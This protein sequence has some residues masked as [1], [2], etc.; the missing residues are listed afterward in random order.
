MLLPLLLTTAIFGGLYAT[1]GA[2]TDLQPGWRY[3]L[4]LPR[5]VAFP[6]KS[7]A[8]I[9][10]EVAERSIRNARVL[11]ITPEEVWLSIEHRDDIPGA[12]TETE[13]LEY[14]RSIGAQGPYVLL[15]GRF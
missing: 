14:W 15:F 2:A 10:A 3:A 12:R 8:E 7:D 11:R 1:R 13:A 6:G 5:A 4:G 9:E